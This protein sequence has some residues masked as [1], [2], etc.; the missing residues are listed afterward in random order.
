[1]PTREEVSLALADEQQFKKYIKTNLDF[2]A[3]AQYPEFTFP[4]FTA[5]VSSTGLFKHV[6]HHNLHLYH[7]I[8]NSFPAYAPQVWGKIIQDIQQGQG[9]LFKRVIDNIDQLAH[10]LIKTPDVKTPVISSFLANPKLVL[11][12]L[13]GN[14]LNIFFE[15]FPEFKEEFELK[16]IY[17]PRNLEFLLL[18]LSLDQLV[19]LMTTAYS[20]KADF[21]FREITRDKDL[22]LHFFYDRKENHLAKF[23]V[24]LKIL[25]EQYHRP[26]WQAA[27][28]YIMPTLLKRGIK[29]NNPA[30]IEVLINDLIKPALK[31]KVI[32][33]KL[34]HACLKTLKNN[35]STSNERLKEAL[36]TLEQLLHSSTTPDNSMGVRDMKRHTFLSGAVPN[37]KPLDASLSTPNPLGPKVS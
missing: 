21:I 29:K 36:V 30:M 7:L 19:Y 18:T 3:A 8:V 33:S 15:K 4:L 14:R 9:E 5:L 25:P 23:F 13:H 12:Y 26:L 2:I 24:G 37:T 28:E 1:M 27:V 10:T 20:E 22:F 6:I 32:T 31:E 35:A 11:N 16:V 34:A 17:T